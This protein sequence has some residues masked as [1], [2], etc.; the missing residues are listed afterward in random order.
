MSLKTALRMVEY[1]TY[2]GTV[3]TNPDL[4]I[5]H[6]ATVL[7]LTICY[8]NTNCTLTLKRNSLQLTF[9]LCIPYQL[10]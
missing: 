1:E 7:H 2:L 9:L 3:H 5:T 8:T 4:I 10:S 6:F